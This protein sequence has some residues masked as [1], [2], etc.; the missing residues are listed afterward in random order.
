[1]MKINFKDKYRKEMENHVYKQPITFNSALLLL[2]IAFKL[3]GVIEW[4]WVWVLSPFWI[5]I[6]FGAV[7]K[8][9]ME[10]GE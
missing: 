2:F 8:T 1:M 10:W 7:V 5:N 9:I 3:C 4:S 6:V